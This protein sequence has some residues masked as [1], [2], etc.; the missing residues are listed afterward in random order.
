MFARRER[1]QVEQKVVK[2]SPHNCNLLCFCCAGGSWA[3]ID[4]AGAR[5]KEERKKEEEKEEEFWI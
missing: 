3:Q 5:E 1:G 4:R 2:D